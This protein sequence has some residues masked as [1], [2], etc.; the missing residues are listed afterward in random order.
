ALLPDAPLGAA[1]AEVR[2]DGLGHRPHHGRTGPRPRPQDHAECALLPGHRRGDTAAVLAADLRGHAR[3]RGRL[4]VLPGVRPLLAAAA[5]GTA[6]VAAAAG[7]VPACPG[8]GGVAG[9]PGRAPG[10]A[11]FAGLPRSRGR[12]KGGPP[13]LEK[14]PARRA[15][16]ACAWPRTRKAIRPP[17]R[18][19]SMPSLLPVRRV[20]PAP[21]RPARPDRRPCIGSRARTSPSAI[22][23]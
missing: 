17:V 6:P 4:P 13:W 10:A 18:T 2:G 5:A 1:V 8:R 15:A 20:R 22:G 7:R 23:S 9:G 19:V 14:Q 11:V 21:R 12:V 16:G 3:Q